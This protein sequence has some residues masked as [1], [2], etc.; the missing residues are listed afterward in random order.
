MINQ[1]FSDG[2]FF[3]FLSKRVGAERIETASSQR[4]SQ[5]A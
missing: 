2:W 3:A 5:T 1:P 4:I